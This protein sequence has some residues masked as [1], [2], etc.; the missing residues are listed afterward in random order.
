MDEGQNRIRLGHEQILSRPP[1]NVITIL[2][3]VDT[4]HHK[5]DALRTT[6]TRW[7]VVTS[8]LEGQKGI[9]RATL[10]PPA[11]EM[12]RARRRR[13][14]IRET[15]KENGRS[16]N[17]T[18]QGRSKSLNSIPT[19]INPTK[20]VSQIT[21]TKE[22]LRLYN[23]IHLEYKYHCWRHILSAYFREQLNVSINQHVRSF[24][25]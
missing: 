24:Q 13:G 19:E 14:E 20:I 16:K 18:A 17:L 23:N 9:A 7:Q 10:P 11:C 3:L 1:H 25:K 2:I 12:G 4:D 22:A 21:N 8:H 6:R 5:L 15:G